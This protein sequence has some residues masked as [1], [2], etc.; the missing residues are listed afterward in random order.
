M[1]FI[2]VDR[3][4]TTPGIL[5]YKQDK[6]SGSN[7]CVY[8]ASKNIVEGGYAVHLTSRLSGVSIVVHANTT[9]PIR[10]YVCKD[11]E[12]WISSE[13]ECVAWCVVD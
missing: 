4:P 9:T 3:K 5:L 11:D 10:L 12:I 6:D 1:S 7:V 2:V 8:A 13:H